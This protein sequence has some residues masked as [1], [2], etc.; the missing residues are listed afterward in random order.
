MQEYLS[1]RV[2]K[3]IPETPEAITLVLKPLSKESV[4]YKAGQFL[5]FLFEINGK[6]LRRSYSLSSAPGVDKDLM[7][8]IKRVENGE[9]SRYLLSNLKEDD[10]L[11]SLM[12]AGRFTISTRPDN[13]RDIFLIGAGSGVTPLFSLLKAALKEEPQ[14]HIT[15]INS[16][17]NRQEA[18]YEEEIESI[19]KSHPGQ[20]TYFSL[21][22]Q[23]GEGE[24]RTRLNI[25]LLEKL[26]RDNLHFDAAEAVFY[27]CGPMT[28]MRMARITLLYMGINEDQ[29]FKE[30][31]L[32]SQQKAYH[33]LIPANT[34]PRVVEIIQGK[35]KQEVAVYP[36]QSILRA[37]LAKGFSIPYSCEIGICATCI[38]RCT[39]GKVI[40][41][42]NEVLTDREVA[43]GWI[44]TCTSHPLD[45]G[46]QVVII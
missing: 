11:Q 46:V 40:M 12:P 6:Q 32:P 10:V 7:I 36:Q 16:N 18:F 15:F 34:P 4:T 45:D 33:P 8:T 30:V 38:A 17:R 44:L 29:L 2:E 14:S 20:L 19:A 22:S 31:F 24:I 42:N 23:P 41:T 13:K 39:S 37:A 9:V 27:L 1:L 25:D 35:E 43:E 5:T 26:V 21:Y 28:F 3:I